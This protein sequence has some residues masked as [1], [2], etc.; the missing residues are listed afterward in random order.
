MSFIK[1]E[2]MKFLRHKYNF[3]KKNLCFCVQS[4]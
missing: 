3:L 2:G 1:R 4:K